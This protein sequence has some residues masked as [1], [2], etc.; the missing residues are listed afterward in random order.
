MRGTVDGLPSPFPLGEMLPAVYQED[1]FVQAWMTGLDEV[2]APV[3]W[4]IDSFESYLDPHTA[5]LDFVEYLSTWVGVE[6]DETWPDASKRAMVSR[7]IGLFRIRGTVAGLRE[8]VAI[9]AG[10]EPEIEESGGTLW[11]ATAGGDLPGQSTAG[12]V[13]RI[14]VPDP[15]AVDVDRLERIVA[16]SKPAHMPHRVEVVQA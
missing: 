11:S 1:E 10:V 2:L 7:A 12:L 4:T 6:L 3:I 8:H 13:V 5:P 16:S 14:R 15:G 9:Y